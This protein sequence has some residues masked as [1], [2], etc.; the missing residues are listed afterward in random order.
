MDSGHK[1]TVSVE[2]LGQKYT[3]IILVV[4]FSIHKEYMI[5]RTQNWLHCSLCIKIV[6]QINDVTADVL[7]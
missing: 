4:H 2:N 1:K 7:F 3:Q 5:T 6:T